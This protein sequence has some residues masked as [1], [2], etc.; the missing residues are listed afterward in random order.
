V[1]TKDYLT[2]PTDEIGGIRSL[3][4]MMGGRIVCRRAYAQRG[5][6]LTIQPDVRIHHN[7][8][9]IRRKFVASGWQ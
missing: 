9:Q 5:E 2:A 4:T 6:T 1:L 8:V 3:L 7:L